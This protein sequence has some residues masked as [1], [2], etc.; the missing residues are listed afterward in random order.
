VTGQHYLEA[1]TEP[2]GIVEELPNLFW[3]PTAGNVPAPD[4][5]YFAL[6]LVSFPHMEDLPAAAS[7]R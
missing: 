4:E 5:D 7:A 3:R 6:G 1:D 2:G